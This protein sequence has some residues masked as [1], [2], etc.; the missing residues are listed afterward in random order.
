VEVKISFWPQGQDILLR[1]DQNRRWKIRKNSS[2]F[3]SKEN[4]PLGL[5]FF[6]DNRKP[7]GIRLFGLH[8]KDS[9]NRRIKIPGTHGKNIQTSSLG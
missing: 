9:Y 4:F 1:G 5:R 6:H 7:K 2:F 8:K 3:E